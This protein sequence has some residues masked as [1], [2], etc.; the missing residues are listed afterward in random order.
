MNVEKMTR[1]QAQEEM[2]ALKRIFPLVEVFDKD[3]IEK[4]NVPR[5]SIN[6]KAVR[7]ARSV[8][9]SAFAEKKQITKFEFLETEIY[10]VIAHY[11]EIDGRAS[12]IEMAKQ[13]SGDSLISLNGHD[14]FAERLARNNSEIYIDALTGAY[15]RRY[16][17]EYLKNA[18]ISAGVVMIDLDDFKLYNDTCGHDAGDSVLRTVVDTIRRCIRATDTLVRYG[19]DEFLLV[20][21]GITD[22][23]FTQQLRYIKRRIHKAD[24]PEYAGLRLSVSIGGVLAEREPL[25]DAVTRADKNMYIAKNRKNTVVT[26]DSRLTTDDANKL[27]VLIVDDS[28][29][30]RDILSSML[31]SDFNIMEAS[32]GEECLAMLEEYGTAISIVLLD[33]VMP[34]IC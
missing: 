30:N 28:E 4:G 34:S 3:E 9:E 23:R 6:G 14:E 7:C 12:V 8:A 25:A 20:M 2:N 29:L 1:Q 33:I 15:N 16:F 22:D 13:L 26:D 27:N 32:N 10:Q 31:K 19:G 18:E 24:I 17:E 21:P 11:V 5:L